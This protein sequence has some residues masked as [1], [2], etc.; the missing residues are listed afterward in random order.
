MPKTI[1]RT[2]EPDPVANGAGAGVAL[3]AKVGVGATLGA[4]SPAAGVPAS[5]AG[6]PAG[7]APAGAVIL[8]GASKL[9]K[10]SV[11]AC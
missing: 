11:N 7:T 3:G 4:A 10:V 9:L 5:T 6:V 1:G 2:S 8:T